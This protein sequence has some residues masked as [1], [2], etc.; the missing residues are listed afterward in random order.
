MRS[1][2]LLIIERY[3]FSL[4]VLQHDAML[5]TC[6]GALSR[7][8]LASVLCFFTHHRPH[9]AGRDMEFFS[10]ARQRGWL[11]EEVLTRKYPVC[12]TCLYTVCRP[13]DTRHSPCSQKI[14]GRKKY[15]PRFMAGGSRGNY[16]LSKKPRSHSHQKSRD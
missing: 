15:E 16:S 13:S 3:M 9:L 6:E 14:L 4:D 2:S 8:R 11:C 1:H 7:T 10:K 12:I 5:S